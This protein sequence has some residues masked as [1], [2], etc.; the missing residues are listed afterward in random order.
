[1]C[2]EGVAPAALSGGGG[3]LALVLMAD[4]EIDGDVMAAWED[5]GATIHSRATLT[6]G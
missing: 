3:S 1:M 4:G 6:L 2:Q 5:A